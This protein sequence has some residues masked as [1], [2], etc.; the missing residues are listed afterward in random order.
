MPS[1]TK[2]NIADMPLGNYSS[3]LT[4]QVLVGRDVAT[5]TDDSSNVLQAGIPIFTNSIGATLS[6]DHT[7]KGPVPEELLE[8]PSV[9]IAGGGY[10]HAKYAAERVLAAGGVPFASVRVGQ[11]TGDA[12]RGAWATT[13]WFPI[14]VKTSLALGVLPG[15]EQ[16]SDSLLWSLY[17]AER[18]NRM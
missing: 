7:T 2:V 3:S 14:L 11:I 4:P 13:D 1:H 16:V 5:V 10:G 18:R 6:W 17:Y 15:D 12:P 9:A 8:D